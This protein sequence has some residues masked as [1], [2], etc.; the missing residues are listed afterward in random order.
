MTFVKKE[1]I[2]KNYFRSRS[3]YFKNETTSNDVSLVAT[4]IKNNFRSNTTQFKRNDST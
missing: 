1:E 4:F 3:P 2:K